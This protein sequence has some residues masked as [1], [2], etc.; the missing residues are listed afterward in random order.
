MEE[1]S[2]LVG[3]IDDLLSVEDLREVLVIMEDKSTVKSECLA[4]GLPRWTVV[5]HS[6]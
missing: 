4:H 2:R 1:D 6:L 5:L 3:I